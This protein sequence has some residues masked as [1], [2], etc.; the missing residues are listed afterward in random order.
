MTTLVQGTLGYLDP[1]YFYS[2]QLTEKSDVYSFGVV[3]VELLTG[4]KALNFE[5]KEEERS[6]AMY[7]VLSIKGDRLFELIDE[8]IKRQANARQISEVAMIAAKCLSLRGE[9]RPTMKEVAVELE[10]LSKREMHPWVQADMNADQESEVLIHGSI[11]SQ[12]NSLQAAN[13]AIGR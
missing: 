10:G 4:E 11:R 2:S 7:F 6:L 1:K 9:D 12:N 13:L 8:S 5:R 3:L